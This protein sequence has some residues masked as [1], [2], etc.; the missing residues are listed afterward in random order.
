M[1]TGSVQILLTRYLHANV[2][3]TTETILS[4]QTHLKRSQTRNA[5]LQIISQQ[6]LNPPHK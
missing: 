5:I 2:S 1:I 3:S 4:E 6:N